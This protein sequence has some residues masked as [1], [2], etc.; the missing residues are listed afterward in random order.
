MKT[1]SGVLFRQ[2]YDKSTQTDTFNEIRKRSIRTQRNCT[3]QIKS[4][5]AKVSSTA[6]ISAQKARIVTQTV[7]EELY[8]HTYFLSLEEAKTGDSRGRTQD[9]NS[10]SFRSP[11][12]SSPRS[13][14]DFTDYKYVL[15]SVRSVNRQKLLLDT[16]CEI[17]AALALLDIQTGIKST[18]TMTQHLDVALMESGSVL[19]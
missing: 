3:E 15:P 14:Q 5:C 7:Y 19:F 6:H 9:R 2:T 16:Q 13:K 11:S 18:S 10:Q 8:G 1:R 4:T 17:D 12:L